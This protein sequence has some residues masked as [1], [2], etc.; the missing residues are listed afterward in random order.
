MYEKIQFYPP[1]KQLYLLQLNSK[2]KERER[3]DRILSKSIVRK[4]PSEGRFIRVLWKENQRWSR[5]V[6]DARCR[7]ARIDF[8]CTGKADGAPKVSLRRKK[9]EKTRW[10][11]AAS[12][13]I[14][15]NN[16]AKKKGGMKKGS[17]TF[18]LITQNASTFLTVNAFSL[19]N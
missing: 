2:E 13:M 8:E 15:P 7:N 12:R 14:Y 9:R 4:L 18:P 5:N 6:T 1:R 16:V 11:V 19:K 17:P 10:T 3:I